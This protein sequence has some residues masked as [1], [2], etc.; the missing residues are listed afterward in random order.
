M[1]LLKQYIL[2][3][4]FM[5]S[6]FSAAARDNASTSFIGGIPV[7]DSISVSILTCTPGAELYSKFGHTALRVKNHTRNKDIVFNYGCFDYSE[8]NFVFK[9]LLGQTD[10]MLN[11]EPYNYLV[12]RYG[13]MGT[14]VKEQVLNLT[15]GE[16]NHLYILLLDNIR[17]E[18]QE[19][20]YIWLYDNCTERARN[21]V[22]KAVD[23]AIVY[24]R[25]T[26]SLTIRQMLHQ[27]LKEDPWTCFGIDMILGAE[28]DQPVDKRI[29]MF[30]PDF[31]SAEASEAYI[32]KNDG[33]RIP[34]IATTNDI[35][36]ETLK[37]E[38]ASFLLSPLLA[39][40]VLFLLSIALFMQELVKSRYQMWLDIPLLVFQGLAGIIV[41]FLFFFSSHPAVDSNWLII[42]LNPIP[43]FYAGWII[44]CQKKGKRNTLSYLNIGILVIFSAIMLIGPQKYNPAMYLLVLTFLVRAL[45]QGHFAYHQK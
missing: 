6:H 3:I 11:A 38:Q 18:N 23:G 22:E 29:Q 34:Y 4:V 40:S 14:G 31:F 41:S 26:V 20:R 44:C 43:L 7:M 42:I 28:I 8:H 16:A 27:C 24:N 21:M 19:Y 25:A 39:L 37:K 13:Y 32:A 33:S 10:Y 12:E 17:P 30:L 36:K 45:S 2:L 5:L 35:I 9:F 1:T 15:Q